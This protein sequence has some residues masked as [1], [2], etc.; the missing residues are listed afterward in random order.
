MTQLMSL[1]V[2]PELKPTN[3][4]NNNNNNNNNDNNN[5]NNNDNN[6]NNNNE[7]NNNQ[8]TPKKTISDLRLGAADGQAPRGPPR[9]W[10]AGRGLGFQPH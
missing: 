4:T 9:S 2:D 1:A 8:H 5:N 3:Q 6:N 10:G 7:N